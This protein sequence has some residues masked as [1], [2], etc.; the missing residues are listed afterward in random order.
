M[1]AGG[2]DDLALAV[3]L[4]S[5]YARKLWPPEP[6]GSPPPSGQILW[7]DRQQTFFC[8]ED[9]RLYLELLTDYSRQYSLEL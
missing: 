3:A 5:W 2:H 4:A 8:D 9:Y 6:E 1:G 7:L